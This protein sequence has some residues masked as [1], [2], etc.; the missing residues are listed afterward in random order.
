VVAVLA[1]GHRSARN[2]SVPLA[3]LADES[4]VLFPRDYAPRLYDQLVGLCRIA[5]FE[6]AVRIESF[7][8]GWE[9]GL[10]AEGPVVSIT[11]ESVAR[12]LPPG[13]VAVPLRDPVPRLETQVLS[14]RDDPSA[15]LAAFLEVA[16]GVFDTG[17][18]L[19]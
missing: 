13:L 8:A 10:L 15:A 3:D 16:A 1:W 7:H 14:R 19:R 12:D 11:P 17:S 6:P 18:V 5:G 9:L 4:F 2:E